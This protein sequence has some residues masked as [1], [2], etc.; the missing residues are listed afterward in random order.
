MTT[1]VLSPNSKFRSWDNNGNPLVGGLLTT[2]AA[3]TTTPIATYK[4]SIGTL[5]TNPIV[6]NFRGEADLWLTPNV[7][8]KL[9]LTDS[10]GN[11]I[12]GWPIDNVV[13]SQLIT[14][15]GGIDTGIANAYILNFTASFTSYTD[16]IVL[17]WIP[18]NT[19]TGASTI[20][21]NGLGVINITNADGSAL[22]AGE[23][24][25]NVPATILI[26]GGAAILVSAT[27]TAYGSFTCTW[28]GFSAPPGNT[29]ITYR[30]NGTLVTLLMPQT[31]GTSNAT[32]FTL[33]GIPALLRPQT[34]LNQ[35]QPIIGLQDNGALV[36]GGLANVQATGVIQFFKDGTQPV[37]TAAGAKGFA[38]I[39]ALTYTI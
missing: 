26:K 24:I 37:W 4:D 23:I 20:N 12:P 25:A 30:K 36:A 7:A 9:A 33:T 8:Y 39:T 27:S 18:A 13:S 22:L 31:V 11:V 1:T 2:Y 19:N 29:T 6:L 16:G 10:A 38:A 34:I 32:T 21:I 5:N 17:Y 35:N 3:G 28:G 14:L 15:Y